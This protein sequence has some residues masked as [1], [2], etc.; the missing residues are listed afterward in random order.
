MICVR[1]VTASRSST[2]TSTATRSGSSRG[3]DRQTVD[4]NGSVVGAAASVKDTQRRILELR[5]ATRRQPGVAV[6][7]GVAFTGLRLRTSLRSVQNSQHDDLFVAN[8]ID[9]DDRERREGDLSRALNATRASNVWERC[10]CADAFDHSVRDSLCGV[11]TAFGDV[12]SD[13]FEVVRGA[14]RPA[15]AH[16]PR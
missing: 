5:S 3:L 8:F 9:S 10:Q 1:L 4:R 14:R 15:D 16:Q 11:R 13:P 7:G 2:R 6:L 12:V